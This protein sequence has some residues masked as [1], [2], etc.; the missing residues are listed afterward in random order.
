[1]LSG[2]WRAIRGE[3][4]WSA[5]VERLFASF[6]VV[7]IFNA[8][9]AA[10]SSQPPNPSVHW[11][12]HSWIHFMKRMHVILSIGSFLLAFCSSSFA[13]F[14]FHRVLAGGFDARAPSAAALLVRELEF[15]FVAC[16]SYFFAGSMLLMGPIAIHSFCM[17]QQGLRS[18]AL[19]ASV[20]CLIV[21]CFALILS[22]F[23]AHL[24]A[25]PYSSYE[26]VLGRFFELSQSRFT[27]G[28]RPAVITIS[29]WVLQ[30]LAALLAAISL[31]ETVPGIYYR[32]I[33]QEH[34]SEPPP[35]R[36]ISLDN[37]EA[38]LEAAESEDDNLPTI[39]ESPHGYDHL[40]GWVQNGGGPIGVPPEVRTHRISPNA[41]LGTALDSYGRGGSVAMPAR[42]PSISDDLPNMSDDH[43]VGSA[44]THNSMR[45]SSHG[46][47]QHGT[48]VSPVT[49]FI[50]GS[51]LGLNAGPQYP[52]TAALN[53][54]DLSRGIGGPRGA[55]A[56]SGASGHRRINSGGV[57]ELSKVSSVASS[58]QSLD[59]TAVD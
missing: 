11:P 27:A 36:S 8:V 50:E 18:N 13:L 9:V 53:A 38:A 22:F 10:Y 2:F 57:R 30:A 20:M 4:I 23:N 25:F 29:A 12:G 15:E 48:R 28:G 34:L 35:R 43:R 39:I 19:A 17:V 26:E 3:S 40:N 24:E 5:E 7:S 49:T 58:I 56:R 45:G 37:T 47:V 1:M 32:D 55:A 54:T 33:A 52:W 59:S 31:I 46:A 44:A 14:A 42:L 41:S 21:G 51:S 16:C 6:F